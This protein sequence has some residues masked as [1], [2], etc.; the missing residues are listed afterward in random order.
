MLKA[1][2]EKPK[3]ELVSLNNRLGLESPTYSKDCASPEAENE[4][5]TKSEVRLGNDQQPIKLQNS[6]IL[7]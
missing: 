6:Q 2:H 1:Y 7:K 4:E 5:D 3:T